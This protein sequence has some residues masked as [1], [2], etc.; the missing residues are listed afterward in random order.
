MLFWV[1]VF[2]S[3][4]WSVTGASLIH[5]W[6]PFWK[7]RGWIICRCR[8][9]RRRTSSTCLASAPGFRKFWQWHSRWRPWNT[10]KTGR[11]LCND[12]LWDQK[13]LYRLS[14]F[15]IE[16]YRICMYVVTINLNILV[17][18]LRLLKMFFC[19]CVQNNCSEFTAF[20]IHRRNTSYN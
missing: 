1:S 7:T 10:W 14:L 6:Q 4:D 13:E 5:R 8:W 19:C 2:D 9:R 12:P 11:V 3:S 15:F 17:L 20:V 16:M 18:S